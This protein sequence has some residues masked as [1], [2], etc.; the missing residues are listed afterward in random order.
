MERGETERRG[1]ERETD[2]QE[3]REKHGGIDR[4]TKTKTMIGR[5]QRIQTQSDKETNMRHLRS[6][7]KVFMNIFRLSFLIGFNGPAYVSASISSS[8]FFSGCLSLLLYR[9]FASEHAPSEL[10]EQDKC[11]LKRCLWSPGW[12]VRW[13]RISFACL[14]QRHSAD[15]SFA[16]VTFRDFLYDTGWT[17]HSHALEYGHGFTIALS[18]ASTAHQMLIFSHYTMC[19]WIV[20]PY[21][22]RFYQFY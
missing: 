4:Q 14:Y 13:R 5:R 10:I 2:R 22:R 19:L 1:K 18:F 9:S 17:V 16:W 21:K 3:Q 7:R 12:A 8:V 15:R 6:T 11:P 20:L